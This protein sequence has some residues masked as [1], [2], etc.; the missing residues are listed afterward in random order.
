ML[1][2][3]FWIFSGLSVTLSITAVVVMRRWNRQLRETRQR[4]QLP[5]PKSRR[6]DDISWLPRWV[7]RGY[8]FLLG[9]FWL[10]CPLCG[11]FSGG[12]EWD[13][14]NPRASMPV[15]GEPNRYRGICPSCTRRNAIE[16]SCTPTQSD[17]WCRA[18]SGRGCCGACDGRGGDASAPETGGLCWDCQG[19]GHAHVGPCSPTLR[20]LER[21]A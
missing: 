17:A 16:C 1:E 9:Y 19:T 4:L 13:G 8:A 12:H 15:P 6:F 11:R 18:H 14:F 2:T 21:P 20:E 10:P 7:H 5:E 3:L